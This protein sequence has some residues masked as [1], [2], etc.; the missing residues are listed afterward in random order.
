MRGNGNAFKVFAQWHEQARAL[1]EFIDFLGWIGVGKTLQVEGRV[2]GEEGNRPW[3]R[4]LP[5]LVSLSFHSI[6]CHSEFLVL[7]VTRTS[8]VILDK[9]FYF[10]GPPFFSPVETRVEPDDLQSSSSF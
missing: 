10:S 2:T 1:E 6:P 7:V 8:C 9:S 5:P 3:K 4:I